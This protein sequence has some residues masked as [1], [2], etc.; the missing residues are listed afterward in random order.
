MQPKQLDGHVPGVSHIVAP[1]GT[2][3]KWGY[4]SGQLKQPAADE[5]CK[6]VV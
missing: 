3:R 1:G 6:G 4:V 2:G 5:D